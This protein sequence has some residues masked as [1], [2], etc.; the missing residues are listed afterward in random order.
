LVRFTTPSEQLRGAEVMEQTLSDRYNSA[1]TTSPDLPGWLEALNA[2]PMFLGLDLRGGIHVLIDVDMEAAVDQALERYTG[3]IRTEL[4]K[5]KVRYLTIT[6]DAGRI[7]VRFRDE[8]AR[9]EAQQ[10]IRKEFRDLTV[11]TGAEGANYFVYAA[12][13]PQIQEEVKDFA[14]EQ[15]ITTLRNRVNALGV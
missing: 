9:D 14:L 12:L 5:Q 10:I 11:D 6:R 15:N 7:A 2:Q 3:D 8:A 1:L 13:P 4:R